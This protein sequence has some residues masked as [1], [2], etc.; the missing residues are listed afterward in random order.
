[1]PF[2]GTVLRSFQEWRIFFYIIYRKKT[3]PRSG[4]CYQLSL[5]AWTPT[6]HTVLSV[7][8][9]KMSVSDLVLLERTVCSQGAVLC[10]AAPHPPMPSDSRRLGNTFAV[11]TSVISTLCFLFVLLS[12]SLTL[13]TLLLWSSYSLLQSCIKLL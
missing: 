9:E 11:F 3:Q 10:R 8:G 6:S 13:V 4:H 7:P 5:W 12:C 2:G 1:M